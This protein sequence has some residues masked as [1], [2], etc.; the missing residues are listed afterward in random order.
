MTTAFTLPDPWERVYHYH[1]RKTAGTSLNAA[2]WALAG[3]DRE[4]VDR[5]QRHRFEH[6]GMVFLRNDRKHL[7]DGDWHY[8]NGHARAVSIVLPPRTFTVTVLR[9]PLERLVSGYQ[10]FH[11]LHRSGLRD[12][13]TEVER[14]RAAGSFGDYLDA[15]PPPARTLQV[16]MFSTRLSVDEAVVRAAAVD[17]VLF[18]DDFAA[19]VGRLGQTLGLELPVLHERQFPKLVQIP[20]A[21]LARATEMLRPEQEFVDELRAL[22]GRLPG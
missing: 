1:V 11:Y 10:Y 21:E 14:E 22:R 19:G 4:Q 16:R 7:E 20:D 5:I 8:A 9:D 6:N 2:F 18:T 3:L 17:A 15:L 13:T 12:G